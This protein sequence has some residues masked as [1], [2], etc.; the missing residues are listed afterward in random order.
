[1]KSL[2]EQRKVVVVKKKI[3][4][5]RRVICLYETKRVQFSLVRELKCGEKR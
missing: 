4:L 5:I 3:E 2:I 1:M